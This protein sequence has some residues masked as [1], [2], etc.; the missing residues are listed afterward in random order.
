MN[1]IVVVSKTVASIV[2]RLDPA[3]I[4]GG[5]P[6]VSGQW[7]VVS[8]LC[9]RR[10]GFF[11]PVSVRRRSAVRSAGGQNRVAVYARTHRQLHHEACTAGQTGFGM[12][13]SEIGRASCRERV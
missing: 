4:G 6:V 11:V 3:W 7:T 9:A 1:S 12:N 2:V 13:M 5:L 10:A 8:N